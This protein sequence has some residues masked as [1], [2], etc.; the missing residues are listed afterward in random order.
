MQATAVTHVCL[1]WSRVTVTWYLP[2]SNSCQ[3][4]QTES[5]CRAQP[6]MNAKSHVTFEARSSA[7][8]ST[9]SS[10]SKLVGAAPALDLLLALF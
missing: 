8:S 5:Q 1:R 3:E 7:A 6:S 10:Y 4:R 2:C 9:R